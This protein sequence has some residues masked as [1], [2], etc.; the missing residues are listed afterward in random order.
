[1]VEN[2]NWRLKMT[3]YYGRFLE[4]A[5][6]C[7]QQINTYNLFTAGGTYAEVIRMSWNVKDE[8]EFKNCNERI[9]ELA[10]MANKMQKKIL[11]G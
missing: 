4:L 2:G 7:E 8:V 5:R 9:N 11:E 10:A 1:M 3:N 6:I